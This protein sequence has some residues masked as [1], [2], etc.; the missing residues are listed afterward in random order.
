MNKLKK[1][2]AL[3]ATLAIASTAFVACDKDNSSSTGSTN[4]KADTSTSD[5]KAEDSKQEEAGP[6]VEFEDTGD[7]LSILCWTPDDV[8]KMI[9]HF[10]EKNADY[11]GKCNFVKIGKD[12]AAAR[13]EYVTYFASGDDADLFVLEADWILEYINDDEYTAPMSKLGFKDSDFDGNYD[14]TIQVGTNEAGVLKAVSWQATPGAYVYR[15]SLAEQYL[16]VKTPD[17]M[18]AKVKDW[19]TLQATGKELSEKTNGKVAIVD[20]LGGMWQVYSYN[21]SSAW[22]DKDNKLVIDD[23]CKEYADIAKSMWDNNYVTHEAQWD[24]PAWY[25]I[26]INGDTLGYFF[27]TWCLGTGSMLS[28]ASGGINE[29]GSAKNEA[30]YG[31]YSICAGPSFYAWGGSW[32]AVSPSCDNGTMARD[33]VEFFTVKEDSMKSYALFK[34]EFVNNP[35]VMKAIVDEKSN[36]N[37]LLGGADQF[38]VLYDSA[39]KIK[40]DNI[41]AYDAQIKKMYNDAISAYA[42]GEEGFET[43]DKAMEKFKENAATIAGIIV[44]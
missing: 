39:S 13:E 38:A 11:A 41:T 3:V 23:Y 25:N 31:D 36:K 19:A 10:E 29:D 42:K 14:Y 34:S 35:T 22:V 20:T 24:D 7:K 17:E 4:S 32:L 28:N 43:Y 40:M 15:T 30:V 16:G 9:E 2:L 44:E 5:S 18:Q 1:T 37:P 12:G 21:R 27:C 6:K 26:G 33:F 8:N